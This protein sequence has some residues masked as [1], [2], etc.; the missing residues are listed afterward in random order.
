[1]ANSSL[2]SDLKNKVIAE[3]IND[4]ELFY[5]IDSPDV[6]D[7]E[8]ADNLINKNIFRFNQNPEILDTVKTFLTVQV[9]IIDSYRDNR[10]VNIDLIIKIYSHYNHMIVDNIQKVVDNRNDYISILLDS[11]FNGRYS[12]GDGKNEIPLWKGLHLY[13]NVEEVF[14]KDYLYRTMIF[15]T[16]DLNDSLCGDDE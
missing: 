15:T 13:S 5:A 9:N 3:I 1:M 7:F 16:K 2:I 8:D 4:E 6:K 14:Q 10:Y 12:I 11:K